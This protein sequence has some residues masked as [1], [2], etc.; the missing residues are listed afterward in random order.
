M[1]PSAATRRRFDGLVLILSKSDIA[2]AVGMK[3]AVESVENAFEQIGL[4]FAV[5]PARPSV[6]VARY[7]GTLLIG[8]GY[9]S[10]GEAL[11]VKVAT[12]YPDNAKLG[13]ATVGSIL[14]LFDP[15]TGELLALMEG[16]YLTAIKTGAEGAVGAKWLAR[17][18]SRRV[19]IIGTGIQG[20]AQLWG[21]VETL[22][23]D[24]ALVYSRNEDR[25][26][27]FSDM[28]TERFG[29]QVRATKSPEE[30]TVESDIVVAA[31][32]SATPVFKGESLKEGVHITGVGSFTPRMRELD[33]VTIERAK[34]VFVDNSEAAEVGDLK[35]AMDEGRLERGSIIHLSEVVTGRVVGR[36]DE[37]EITLFKSVGGAAYDA[38]VAKV[39]YDLAVTKGWG[40]KIQL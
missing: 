14:A 6:E 11:V 35:M 28:A 4:G 23:I 17:K 33:G 22:K 27:A 31:T 18:N 12:S 8:S 15:G 40:R 21:L 32:T 37:S 39:T 36:R 13:L 16:S 24:E 34:R 30:V 1:A 26:R 2:G 5:T 9:L 29:I 38:A 10:R 20:E 3:Q 7:N 25:R 19:G